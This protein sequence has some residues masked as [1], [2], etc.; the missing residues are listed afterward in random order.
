MSELVESNRTLWTI[1]HSNHT[2]EVFLELLSKGPGLEFLVD[3][4]TTPS[5][6]YSPQFNQEHLK[7]TLLE[8]GIKY[9]HLAG[10][11]G[12]PSQEKCYSDDGRV[13]YDEMEKTPDYLRDLEAL[14]HNIGLMKC[15]VMCSCGAPEFCHRTLSISFKLVEHGFEVIDILP[16]GE[17]VKSTPPESSI[18]LFDFGEVRKS[19]LPVRQNT[20]PKNFSH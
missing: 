18:S 15:V 17:L 12:R 5:S 14:E 3:V 8:I 4:R 10:I 20:P 16:N 19:K 1:G 13:I 9:V 7:A 11:G 6:S 2:M